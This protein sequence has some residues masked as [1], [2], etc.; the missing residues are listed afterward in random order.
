MNM[1]R[2]ISRFILGD[3]NPELVPDQFLREQPDPLVAAEASRALMAQ[4]KNARLI[5]T[6]INLRL[7]TSR[8]QY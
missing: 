2:N 7:L 6:G 8:R 5:L 4:T 3:Q 1:K